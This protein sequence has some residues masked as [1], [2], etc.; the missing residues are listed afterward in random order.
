MKATLEIMGLVLLVA[1]IAVLG[2]RV[3]ESATVEATTG[4]AP[5][6]TLPASWIE[7]RDAV[8]PVVEE[9]V[10]ADSVNLLGYRHDAYGF[11]LLLPDTWEGYRTTTHMVTG[12][13]VVCVWFDR[14]QPETVFQV[15]VYDRAEWERLEGLDGAT[16]SSALAETPELVYRYS[17]GL[18][19]GDAFLRDRLQ[20]VP[21]VVRSFRVTR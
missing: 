7:P 15:Y 19:T 14:E 12:I 16:T 3:F 4:P 6:V 21:S 9:P 1:L 11:E 5:E 8:S 13:P 20:E 18:I 10:P 17:D 2:A